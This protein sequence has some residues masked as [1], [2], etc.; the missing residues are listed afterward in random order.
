MYQ[1]SGCPMRVK[2]QDRMALHVLS[3]SC[4]ARYYTLVKA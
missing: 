1:C 4:R 2:D 3:D